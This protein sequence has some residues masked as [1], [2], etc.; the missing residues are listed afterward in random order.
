MTVK[1]SAKIGV[2][3]TI[4]EKDSN[5]SYFSKDTVIP[6]NPMPF[7]FVLQVCPG[8]IGCAAVSVPVVT[9]SP[10]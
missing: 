6:D 10:D 5:A 9:I 7:K 4:Y 8:Q 1:T 3:K 2:E